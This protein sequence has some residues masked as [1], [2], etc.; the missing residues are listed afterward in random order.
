MLGHAQHDQRAVALEQADIGV[1]VVARRDRVDD[2]VERAGV[3]SHF[4]GL[5]ADH[6]AVGAEVDRVLA[7]GGRRGEGD[8]FG[9]H[10][11]RDLDRH[12]AETADADDADLLARTGVPVT[13]RR[14]RGD[15]RAEQRRD[16]G[17]LL[18]RVADRKDEAFIDDDP[19]RIAAHGVAGRIRRLA[20]VGADE[21]VLAILF[22][23]VMARTA[24]AAAVDHAADADGVADLEAADFAAHRADGADDLV[25]GN[26]GEKGAA[27]LAAHGVQVRVAH[28]AIADVD[29]DVARARLAPFDGH[30]FEGLVAG[31]CA[32]GVDLHGMSLLSEENGNWIGTRAAS[33]R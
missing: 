27:P 22:E 11:M 23:I 10:G 30:G 13:Q 2:Q 17:K 5:A 25:T 18:R 26:A 4:L 31:M 14:V 7:L 21:A 1:E 29:R 33:A 20:V 28:A 8:D 19:A 3:R 16:G 15:A 24:V 12:M 9:P 6:R 32:I